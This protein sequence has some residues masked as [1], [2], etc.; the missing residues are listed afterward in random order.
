MMQM[1]VQNRR[2]CLQ[3]KN[4][5]GHTTLEMALLMLPFITLLF[6]VMEFG[7]YFLHQHTLQ[8]A[9]REGMR[10]AQVG[11]ILENEQGVSL[12]REESIIETIKEKAGWVMDPNEVQV[13]IFKVGSNY[14]SP[15]NWEDLAPNAGNPADFMRVKTRYDYHFVFP[16]I[17]SLL[18]D[19]GGVSLWAEATY[20]N[21]LFDI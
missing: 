15:M 12:T 4:I 9:T 11:V 20:R 2:W 6:A 3:K 14:E 17:G 7:W 5:Q 21:E 1:D 10:L 16:V 13:W 19:E 8:F 18:S